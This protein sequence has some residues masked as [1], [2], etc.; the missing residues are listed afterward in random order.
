MGKLMTADK[1]LKQAGS[2]VY[3]VL[4]SSQGR[5]LSVSLPELAALKDF[6]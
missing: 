2:S 3:E 5:M 6:E 4:F 1:H